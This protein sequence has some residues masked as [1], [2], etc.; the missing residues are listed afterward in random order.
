M[1][2]RLYENLRTVSYTPFYLAEAMGRYAEHG[3]E[4]DTI[5][6]PKPSET[7]LGLMRGD[8]DVC[9]GGPMRV[10]VH[11]DA[12]PACPLVCFGQVV[13]R[14]PFM[15]LGREPN[16]DFRFT[17]LI[18]KRVAV[19]NEVETPWMTMQDDLGRAGI[20]PQSIVRAPDRTMA[21]NVA[22][23]AAGE[24]D[25]IQVM[26]PYAANAIGDRI[27]HLWHRFSVRG[28]VAFTSFY[29]TRTFAD[30]RPEVCRALVRAL[31]ASIET[32]YT[33]PSVEVAAKIGAWFADV[34]PERLA[35]AIAGYQ[36]AQ[37][38]TV[39]PSIPAAHLV[40]LKAGLL[41]GG[42]IARDVPYDEVVVDRFARE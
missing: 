2:I 32:L 37:I 35:S 30:E 8:V 26:E 29:T 11:H 22:A 23:L 24:V 34:T 16:I 13:G 41:S 31:R 9:W 42:L 3:L 4:V 5:R 10:L 25:V 12:D 1:K 38:W 28:E 15:L 20:D 18:G 33:M 17:D 6:S 21:E 39:D 19:M 14:D 36:A 40:R 7:P 27:G